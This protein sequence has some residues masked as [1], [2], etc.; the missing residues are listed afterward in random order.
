MKNCFSRTGM[1]KKVTKVTGH[2]V[3]KKPQHSRAGVR[4]NRAFVCDNRAFVHDRKT[5]IR[6]EKMAVRGEKWA[7]K[8]TNDDVQTRGKRRVFTLKG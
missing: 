3:T 8:C 7:E 1:M 5:G 6:G 2:K 4:D